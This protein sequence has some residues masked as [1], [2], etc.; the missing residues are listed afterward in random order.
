[1]LHDVRMAAMTG[2]TAASQSVAGGRL[3][4]RFF[5]ADQGARFRLG[6]RVVRVGKSPKVEAVGF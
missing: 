4:W 3:W 2:R 6:A 5:D 1:M